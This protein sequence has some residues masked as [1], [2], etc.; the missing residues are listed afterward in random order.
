MP[1]VDGP[2]LPVPPRLRDE[3]A[4]AVTGGD[5]PLRQ[6]FSRRGGEPQTS[7]SLS[8]K[9]AAHGPQTFLCAS[10]VH[11]GDRDSVSWIALAG[12]PLGLP[13]S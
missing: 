13:T 5:A 8:P 10:W 2:P 4:D 1:L 9:G 3:L 6:Y 7:A 12:T 11:E